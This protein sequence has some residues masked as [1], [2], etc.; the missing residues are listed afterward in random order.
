LFGTDGIRGR[1][2]AYPM[3]GQTA[4]S[5]GKAA[6]AY[7]R[8]IGKAGH[9]VIGR[10]TRISGDMLA[11]A[12]AAGICS[13]G[14][15][16][17]HL[18]VIPT[19]AVAFAAVNTAAAGGVV[20]SA[21]HNPFDDNGIKLFDSHGCKLPD[22]AED[23]I[24]ILMQAPESEIRAAKAEQIGQIV[25]GAQ[26]KDSYLQFLLDSSSCK[27][28]K[29]LTLVL[30][31]ANGATYKVAPELFERLEARV[32]TLY[33]RPSGI[34]INDQ[35]GS[36]HP[37]TM[38]KEVV[39]QKA[40]IGLAFDGDGDRLIAVD[41]KGRV[42]S[43]DQIMAICAND[44]HQ[45]GLL[46]NNLVVSTV[47]SNLGFGKALRNLGIDVVAT[48]VG[49]RYVMQ[50]M[51]ARDA[52]LG[53]EDSGHMIFKDRHT[54]G[55][56]LFAALRLI[57]AMQSSGKKLSEL[58]EIMK[59]YPQELINVTVS[60]KPALDT[61]PQIVEVIEAVESKLADQG[62]VLVRYSGTQLKC[63]VMVEGPTSDETRAYAQRIADVVRSVL[64]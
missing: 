35:C 26:T 21:S 50:E 34:N 15:N 58:S 39:R 38:A 63:R 37:E 31:C 55:D 46:K 11:Q 43:G 62:R 64:T 1:A 32:T 28:L 22:Q 18:G 13:A 8:K 17:Q 42:L 29:H 19:P 60:H 61:I 27:S 54:T 36:Q 3:D 41:Q 44:L 59:V 56:G 24:E 57:E 7:F 5:V 51:M 23:Q 14:L 25:D 2:N 6:A 10:D 16:V 30:D 20:I 52:V 4:F 9:I 53:G 33:C 45:K 40:D 12:V 48:Q 49:D 47:M